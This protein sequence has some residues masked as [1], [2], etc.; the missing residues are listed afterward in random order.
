M[1]PFTFGQRL[2]KADSFRPTSRARQVNVRRRL[3]L[4][5]LEDRTLLANLAL[6]LGNEP[7]VAVN[8]NNPNVVAVAEF[9]TVLISLNGG[10]SFPT[11]VNVAAPNGY[12]GFGGDA[13]LSFDAQGNLFFGYLAAL[14]VLT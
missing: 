1:R 2:V 14:V 13:S 3:S 5:P 4:E 7:T 8:P 11:V 6:G 9:R 12:S 10:Q